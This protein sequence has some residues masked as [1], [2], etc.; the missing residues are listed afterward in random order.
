MLSVVKSPLWTSEAALPAE[1][2]KRETTTTPGEF[3]RWTTESGIT[4]H[5]VAPWQHHGK[6]DAPAVHHQNKPSASPGN[7]LPSLEEEIHHAPCSCRAEERIK[8]P[9]HPGHKHL[10]PLP[11]GRCY[12]ALFALETRLTNSFYPTAISLWNSQH[13]LPP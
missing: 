3:Y 11:C 12:R 2:E 6:Q 9:T 10:T 5:C 8:D 7:Q 1:P 4:C 13:S